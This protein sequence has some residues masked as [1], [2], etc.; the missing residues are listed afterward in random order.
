MRCND[1]CFSV[2]LSLE[3]DVSN[4]AQGVLNAVVRA[5]DVADQ[6]QSNLDKILAIYQNL[7][8]NCSLD[9]E[10]LYSALPSCSGLNH[11]F[12]C[13]AQLDMSKFA[14]SLMHLIPSNL[15]GQKF[16]GQNQL[17]TYG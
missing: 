16:A 1:S 2:Q 10:V 12:L 15:G 17:C 9:L 13:S 3:N 14:T 4:I 8:T 7:E 11:S 6:S 5:T